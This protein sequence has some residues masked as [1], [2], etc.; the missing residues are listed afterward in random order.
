MPKAMILALHLVVFVLILAAGIAL[1]TW[2]GALW[3]FSM[4]FSTLLTVGGFAVLA[5]GWGWL[6]L[7]PVA[8]AVAMP[9]IGHRILLWPLT[10]AAMI[11]LNG[12]LGPAR[13]FMPLSALGVGGALLLYALPVA[14]ALLIGSTLREALRRSK[15]HTIP[16]HPEYPG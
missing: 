16:N 7:V 10:L 2:R 3:P 15:P 13:D 1:T 11:G 8:A 4:Y 9:R 5:V 14:I 6:W 12:V